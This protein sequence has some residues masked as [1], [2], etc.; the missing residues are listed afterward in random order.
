MASHR[1]LVSAGSD[2]L[3]WGG[4]S[5]GSA[6]QLR[7]IIAAR[8]GVEEAHAELHLAVTAAREAGESWA[9]IGA[10]LDISRRSAVKR[11]GHWSRT[12]LGAAR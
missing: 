6:E 7:R 2:H 11:C 9:M 5:T 3:D 10:A 4:T 8:I 12:G 1:D